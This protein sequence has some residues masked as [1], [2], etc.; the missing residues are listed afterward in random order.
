[1]YNVLLLISVFCLVLNCFCVP[2]SCIV[3]FL[4]RGG[5][6]GGVE[7]R[8]GVLCPFVSFLFPLFVFNPVLFFF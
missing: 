7:I 1:M 4:P 3:F 5:G 8:L 2:Q 6:G